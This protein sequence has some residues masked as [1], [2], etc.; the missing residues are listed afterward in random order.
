MKLRYATTAL[1]L[2]AALLAPAGLQAQ[3]TTFVPK[4]TKAAVDSAKPATVAAT[5]AR[6]DS[7]TRMSIT[8]MKDWVDSAAGIPTTDTT[9]AAN[10]MATTTET[11]AANTATTSST[12]AHATTTFSNGAIAPN[13]ASP[14][15]A[16]LAAGFASLAA[17]LLLLFGLRRRAEAVSVKK[18]R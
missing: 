15:P 17:G 14:L 4:P 8:S 12:S 10:T 7:I 16:Y 5:K 2:S 3:F 9:A 11:V 1:A 13:T 6:S 18:R